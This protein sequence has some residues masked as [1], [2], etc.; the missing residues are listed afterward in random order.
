MKTMLPSGKFPVYVLR[1]TLPAD[2]VDVNVHPNKMD[3]RF[4]EEEELAGFIREAVFGALTDHSLIPEVSLSPRRV[5]PTEDDSPYEEQS[6]TAQALPA[7]AAATPAPPRN[8]APVGASA[9]P[10]LVLHEPPKPT[11]TPF[12]RDY[13]I[14]GLLFGTYWLLT[15]GDS[16][17]L[18]DQHAAHERVLYDEITQQVEKTAIPSQP[19]LEAVALRLTP[20]ETQLLCDHHALFE[21]FG[22]VIGGHPPKLTGV[23]FMLRGPLSVAL[24]TDALDALEDSTPVLKENAVAMMA[25]KAAVKANDHLSE[26]EARALILKLLLLDNPYTCPHGRP[27]MIEITKKEIERK[28]NRV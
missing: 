5:A 27:T 28:F 3:V 25:C 9:P 22:F 23:P 18:I 15:Q 26:P 11:K 17:Y 6:L 8:E 13:Y 7:P 20:R 4:A 12:F 14:H 24:L 1:L 2:R 16:L 10:A 19:L 21:R